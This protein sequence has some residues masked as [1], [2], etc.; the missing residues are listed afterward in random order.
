M[1]KSRLLIIVT[2]IVSLFTLTFSSDVT[3]GDRWRSQKIRPYGDYCPGPHG[4]YG[5]KQIVRSKEEARSILQDFF[6]G[7][8]IAIGPL[9]ERKWFFRAEVFDSE[10]NLIDI[11]IIDKR[12]GRIRSIL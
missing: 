2:L 9:T 8:D 12:T 10:Q 6:R 11:I 1:N 4:H 3:A 7:R 5:A